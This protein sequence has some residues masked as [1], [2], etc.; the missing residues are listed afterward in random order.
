MSFFSMNNLAYEKDILNKSYYVEEDNLLNPLDN[1]FS[2]IISD[3]NKN[4]NSLDL[5][6]SQSQI[7]NNSKNS[8]IDK[9]CSPAPAPLRSSQSQ[10]QNDLAMS[11]NMECPEVVQQS[12]NKTNDII[13]ISFLL[14]SFITLLSEF[15]NELNNLLL[16]IL[17][18]SGPY[19]LFTFSLNL[20][21]F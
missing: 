19:I 14:F 16:I 8:D 7:I 20:F 3:E 2:L 1:S 6:E 9:E 4:K 5:F 21:F 17:K 13:N 15:S 12:E 10:I 18:L 11:H